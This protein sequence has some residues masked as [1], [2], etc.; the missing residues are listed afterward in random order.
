HVEPPTGVAGRMRRAD[1]DDTELLVDWRRAFDDEVGPHGPASAEHAVARDLAAN[2][3]GLWLW[4]VGG[5]PV[6]LA[7]ARGPTPSGIRVGPVFTPR[8]QRGH[9]YAGALVGRLT[10]LL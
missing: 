10:Q 9:G 4:E 1:D 2:P 7:G 8:E 3:G 5:E 6:A